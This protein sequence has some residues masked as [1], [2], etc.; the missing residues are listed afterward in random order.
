[1]WWSFFVVGLHFCLLWLFLIKFLSLIIHNSLLSC[2]QSSLML[3]RRSGVTVAVSSDTFQ[4]FFFHELSL[5]A[6][7]G[8]SSRRLVTSQCVTLCHLF[9]NP[10]G[11]FWDSCAHA[12]KVGLRAADA[13]AD[14]AAQ[15]VAAVV[16]LH[17]ERAAGIALK[18]RKDLVMWPLN[19]ITLGHRC[20]VTLLNRSLIT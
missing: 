5:E 1:M 7:L 8:S 10:F 4:S 14:D 15:E 12:R 2:F 20:V 13:P 16:A 6:S 19:S 18:S 11:E 3:N 9:E 17:D